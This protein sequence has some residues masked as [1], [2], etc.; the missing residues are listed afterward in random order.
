MEEQ[1]L[2]DLLGCKK[3][4]PA[5]QYR[6][7]G[8]KYIYTKKHLSAFSMFIRVLL[9]IIWGSIMLS[10]LHQEYIAYQMIISALIY[11]LLA[12]IFWFS[13]G[14]IYS[15]KEIEYEEYEKCEDINN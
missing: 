5:D 6:K 10:L 3:E 2:D 4:Q 8:K 12:A 1:N 9:I 14:N 7:T 15:T 13:L 11:G